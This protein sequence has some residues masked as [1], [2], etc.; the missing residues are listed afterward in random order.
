VSEYLL[1][2]TDALCFTSVYINQ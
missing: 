2:L 1:L